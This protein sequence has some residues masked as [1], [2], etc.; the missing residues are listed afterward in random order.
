M[1]KVFTLM[2]AFSAVF[3]FYSSG[4]EGWDFGFLRAGVLSLKTPA[5]G[6][7]GGKAAF[8]GVGADRRDIKAEAIGLTD[9][10]G[11]SNINDPLYREGSKALLRKAIEDGGVQARHG[12]TSLRRA[13]MR[14]APS[15]IAV[16]AARPAQSALASDTET[17]P[18]P[19]KK[20]RLIKMVPADPLENMSSR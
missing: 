8:S 10:D 15:G 11:F 18:A 12:K 19:F 16:K 9:F 17:V 1:K 7:D 3:L 13:D 4:T 5:K 14:D 20:S 6:E 2:A